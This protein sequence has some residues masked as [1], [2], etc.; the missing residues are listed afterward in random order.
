MERH[1]S[2]PLALLVLKFSYVTTTVGRTSP[3]SWTHIAGGTDLLAVFD[4]V[5]V[6]ENASSWTAE[7]KLTL[8]VLRGTDVLEDLDL[9]ALAR[10]AVASSSSQQQVPNAK[11][12][13]AVIVKSPCLA[14]RYPTRVNQIRRFQLKF[15]SDADYCRAVSVLSEAGCPITESTA[16]PAPPSAP[17]KTRLDPPSWPQ[18][19]VTPP[20]APTASQFGDHGILTP[21][22]ALDARPSTVGSASTIGTAPPSRN[23]P[24]TGGNTTS[25]WL[26]SHVSNERPATAPTF[27]D[28]ESISQ[29]LPPKRELPFARPQW[30]RHALQ[31]QTPTSATE[32]LKPMVRTHSHQQSNSDPRIH[33]PTR[34]YSDGPSSTAHTNS[35]ENKARNE[36]FTGDREQSAVFSPASLSPQKRPSE[37]PTSL[38]K[39]ARP[40]L[41]DSHNSNPLHTRSSPALRFAPSQPGPE[42]HFPSPGPIVNTNNQSVDIQ[43]NRLATAGTNPVPTPEDLSSY[44]L[45]P[46]PERSAFIETWVWQQKRS[47]IIV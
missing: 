33:T 4:R 21:T 16:A 1:S 20:P 17:F 27:P 44:L 38:T 22:T 30:S 41:A 37:G 19:A 13:I 45:T 6:Q 12:P 42:T 36:P 5:R 24:V 43:V 31:N 35:M 40:S 15:S 14:I 34:L 9:G 8:K 18:S 3:L 46:T 47:N 2:C 28:P 23:A 29:L 39:F 32:A 25:P 10:E 26:N 7:S 11:T